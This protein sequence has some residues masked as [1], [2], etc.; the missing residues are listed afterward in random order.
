MK[1][2]KK[3]RPVPQNESN[4]GRNFEPWKWLM[5]RNSGVLRHCE[6]KQI[7][8][9]LYTNIKPV[10]TWNPHELPNGG[11][12]GAIFNFDYSTDGSI[13]IAACQHK[14][15]LM[16]DPYN[17][18]LLKEKQDAHS[19]CVNCVRFL[20]TRL[21]ATCSDDKTV[22]LWDCRFLKSR[23]KTLTGHDYWVKNI[24]YNSSESLLVTSGF[25]GRICTWDINNYSGQNDEHKQVL[26]TKGLMRSKLTSDNKKLI[27]STSRGYMIIIHD[28]NLHTLPTDLYSFKPDVYRVHRIN[29][30]GESELVVKDNP[31]IHRKTNRIEFISDFPSGNEAEVIA[32]LQVHPH[33]WCIVSRNTSTD[34]D[35]EWVCVHDIQS[36]PD[37]ISLDQPS[38]SSSTLKVNKPRLMFYKQEP[39]VGEGFIKELCFSYDGRV[40]CSP[41]KDGVRLLTFNQNCDEICDCVPSEVKNLHV[42]QTNQSHNSYVL[43]TKFSPK[44]FMFVSGS[45]S[46]KVVFHQPVL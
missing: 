16:F 19:D 32:S 9:Y 13:L 22:V 20:D 30:A 24:E 46:G 31:F 37:D 18:Q 28:L 4:S 26:L 27:I 45:L 42:Y 1:T 6:R 5:K 39:N 21:F 11:Q 10:L 34:S 38:T 40:I 41:Y 23:I 33:S 8:P 15:F 3:I 25:D 35:S 17:G 2:V 12:H 43:A 36:T 7:Y 29:S 44:H 14:S